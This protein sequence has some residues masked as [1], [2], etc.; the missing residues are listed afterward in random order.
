MS[1]RTRAFSLFP[2]YRYGPLLRTNPLSWA[3]ISWATCTIGL[4]EVTSLL[5]LAAYQIKKKNTSESI[6]VVE[7]E[8][9]YY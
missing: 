2:S 1:Q 4:D 5:L 6:M 9:N 8:I 3:S 7:L